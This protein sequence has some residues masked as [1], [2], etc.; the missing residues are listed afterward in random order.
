[1]QLKQTGIEKKFQQTIEFVG[2]SSG[3]VVAS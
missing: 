1:M 2:E 3:P